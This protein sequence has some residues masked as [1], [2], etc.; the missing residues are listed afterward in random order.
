MIMF[1]IIREQFGAFT[2][3]HLKNETSGESV[4]FIPEYAAC[5]NG[6]ALRKGVHLHQLV[7]GCSSYEVL[8]DLGKRKFMGSKLFPFPNRIEDGLYTFND[9][10]YQLPINYPDEGHAI[11][12]LVLEKSFEVVKELTT[13][14][15]ASVSLQFDYDGGISGY[16]FPY[17][18][19]IDF[20]LNV[21][22]FTCTSSV[23]NCAEKA[24]PVADG[25]HPYFTLNGLLDNFLLKIP[26]NEIVEV[27][28]RMIPTGAILTSAKYR[29][30]AKIGEEAFDTCFAVSPQEGI[31]ELELTNM[32]ANVTLVMWQETGPNKYNYI[33]IYT[34]PSR[35]F[36][37]IE[38]MT[39]APDVF[40][41]GQGL[42]LL[43]PNISVDFSFGIKIK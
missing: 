8:T 15:E 38:P 3:I 43:E 34:P 27:D 36:I 16:P 12:G 24:I 9:E 20:I 11:H 25:W 28:E 4:S 37:A 31:A 26:S 23:R 35:N 14:E 33:Q 41:N 22:G 7:H 30:G 6:L 18:L 42:I 5:I 40:N 21:E 29:M 17:V 13:D 19:T 32:A 2:Q 39:C 1:K 10:Q